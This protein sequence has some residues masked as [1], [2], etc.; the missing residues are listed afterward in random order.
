MRQPDGYVNEEYP[1]Y[2]CKL[3]KS[4]YGLKQS[5]RCWKTAI[6]TF[7][8]SSGYKQMKSD[9][10]LY[11]KS[12]RDRNGV[13]KFVILLIYVDDILLFANET[14]MLN[15]E[16][17]LIGS[18][19]KIDDMGEVKYILGMLINRNRE[20][21]KMTIRQP[22]YLEGILKR[23]GMEQCKPVSTPLEP[24]KHFLELPDDENPTNINEYQKLIGYLTYV[25]TATRPD[26]ASAVGR[27]LK[28]MSRPSDEH[29]KGAKRILRYI[30]GTINYGL[31]FDGRSTRC[32]LIGYSD[33]DWANDV[34][35]RRSTSGYV[36]QINGSTV[37][38]SSKRQSCVTRSSTE[39]EYV[40]LSHATQEVVWLRR[41]LNDIGEKQDQPSVMNEDNQGAIELS[42]NPRFHNRTKHIDVAYHFIRE[43]VN[44]KS[45]NV[46]YCSTDQMLA[47]VMTKS[48]PRQTFQKFR[49]MLNVKEILA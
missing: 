40:A 27:L 15:E 42:K 20:R 43:K 10:C 45:I 38:W 36:F 34:D 5:A 22:K 32:S 8:K 30:K 3:K 4:I 18:K 37:S 21:G 33:A 28:Y 48:L 35:T 23:F 13:I 14:S 6:G 19:F 7:L 31:V 12:I 17:K 39:A 1:D 47:D 49:D 46:K 26:L 41:L 44:D 16:K 24:G 25:A 2:V 11:M 29:W 9:S